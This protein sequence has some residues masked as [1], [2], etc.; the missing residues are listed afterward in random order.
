MAKSSHDQT[1]FNNIRL[2]QRFEVGQF[3]NFLLVADSG[4]EIK[5]YLMTKLPETHTASENLLNASII[6]TR[7]MVE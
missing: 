7:C 2:R 5:P 6:R 3:G 1:I 4:C